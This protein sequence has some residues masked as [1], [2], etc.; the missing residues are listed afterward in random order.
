MS[1]EQQVQDAIAA[2]EEAMKALRDYG[3]ITEDDDNE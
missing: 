2:L 3:L 1:N